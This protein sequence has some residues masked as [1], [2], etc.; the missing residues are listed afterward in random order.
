MREMPER[1]SLNFVVGII[2]VDFRDKY[3]NKERLI[4]D[5]SGGH[6][7]DVDIEENG[8]G[9]YLIFLPEASKTGNAYDKLCKLF[10]EGEKIE[11]RSFPDTQ[12]HDEERIKVAKKTREELLR[13]LEKE[14]IPHKPLLMLFDD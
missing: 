3:T 8:D 2:E 10:I 13:Y 7:S 11:I 4:E 12:N 14:K 5:F 9:S 6:Y 1:K